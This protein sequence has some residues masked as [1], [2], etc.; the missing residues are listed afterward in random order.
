MR[1]VHRAAQET[2]GT[3]ALARVICELCGRSTSIGFSARR[4]WRWHTRRDWGPRPADIV[5]G[6][7]LSLEESWATTGESSW[8][9]AGG[10]ERV[11]LWQ[12]SRAIERRW[13]GPSR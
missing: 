12:A 2:A 3:P 5:P 6:S 7:D 13:T 8:H 9:S 1:T 4:H 10:E 11:R